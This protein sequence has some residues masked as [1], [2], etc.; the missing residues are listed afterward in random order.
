MTLLQPIDKAIFKI[1]P[2]EKHQTY[3]LEKYA[4]SAMYNRR[5]SENI[6]S[7]LGTFYWTLEDGRRRSTLML[8][9]TDQGSLLDLYQKNEP[10][11]NLPG[12]IEFWDMF[13]YV[14]Q[15]LDMMHNIEPTSVHIE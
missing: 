11:H 4:Y 2:E 6:L 1:Y 15:G 10:P 5:D 3:N 12:I 8:E 9:Y 14:I 13:R 7:C